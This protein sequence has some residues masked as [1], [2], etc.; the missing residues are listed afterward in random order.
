[1]NSLITN[2]ATRTRRADYI[3]EDKITEKKEGFCKEEN[4]NMDL[5]F[6]KLQDNVSRF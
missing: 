2:Q 1:M 6:N 5:N 4:I 3:E